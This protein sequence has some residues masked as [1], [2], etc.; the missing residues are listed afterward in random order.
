CAQLGG[1]TGNLIDVQEA[2]DE[3]IRRRSDLR[4]VVTHL[5]RLPKR[6]VARVYEAEAQRMERAWCGDL[7]LEPLGP[8]R[9]RQ[10]VHRALDDPWV[11]RI[12]RGLRP[13]TCVKPVAIRKRS[14]QLLCT[15]IRGHFNLPK[16]VW[17][18]RDVDVGKGG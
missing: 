5:E 9:R 4:Q 3:P 15:C 18:A 14:I 10:R 16:S 7:L 17:V 2:V 6:Y 8:D 1:R 13:T 12:E 11:P